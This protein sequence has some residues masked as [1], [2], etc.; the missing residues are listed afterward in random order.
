MK[1]KLSDKDHMQNKTYAGYWKRF[2]WAEFALYLAL[3]VL[4]LQ[5]VSYQ[6][7]SFAWVAFAAFGLP[8]TRYV[9]HRIVRCPSC[10][11]RFFRPLYMLDAE[12]N[13]Q[14]CGLKHSRQ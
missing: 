1:T 14:H 2:F 9:I 13:C 6:T 4:F 8:L 10:H 11:Q 3:L 5:L 12:N 7:F